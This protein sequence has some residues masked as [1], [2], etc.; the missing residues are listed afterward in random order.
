MSTKNQKTAATTKVNNTKNDAN[1]LHKIN[2]EKHAAIVANV[3]EK[4]KEQKS[5]L[6]N[7]P[8]T[9]TALQINGVEGKNFRS[10]LRT[11][12]TNFAN[13]IFVFYK[14][15]NSEKL[16]LEVQNFNV[17]YKENFKVNDFSISSITHTKEEK[18]Q[19]YVHMLEIIK[20]VQI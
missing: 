18:N 13:N 8:E 15:K 2:F 5:T 7:Y 16:I 19:M 10:K 6:Y 20:D 11:K 9:F 4:I 17:F 14:T 1:K 12:L 3:S